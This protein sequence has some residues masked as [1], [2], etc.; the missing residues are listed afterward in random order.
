MRTVLVADDEAAILEVFSEIISGLGHQVV[1]ARD[2]EEALRLARAHQPDLIVSDYMMP[3]RTGVELLRELRTEAPLAQVPFI[4]VSAAQPRGSEEAWKFL[5]KPVDLDE[6]EQVIEAALQ[7]GPARASAPH[8]SAA[9]VPA[10]APELEEMLNWVA[11][12][13]RTPLSAAKLHAQMVARELAARGDFPCGERMGALLRQFDRM[14]ELVNSVLGAAQLTEGKLKLRLVRGDFGVFLRDVL[15]EWRQ[16]HPAHDFRLRLLEE[17][18]LVSFDAER[19]R[20]IIDHLISNAVRYGGEARRV[21]VEL[22]LLPGLA[23]VAVVDQGEG[24]PAAELPRIFN[25]FY[26]REGTEGH[27]HGLG[28]YI[29]AAL[30]RLHGGSLTARSAQGR[31]STFTLRLPRI[32]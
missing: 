22:S 24:I 7:A 26:R 2:G 29:S 8:A 1:C 19:V 32:A 4:L 3:R 5:S 13:V 18:V 15:A 20:Q 28:L 25:R 17:P 9:Q 10:N 30:A 6:L 27:G 11:H 12:E 23:S 31:G 16:T 14:E 21:D